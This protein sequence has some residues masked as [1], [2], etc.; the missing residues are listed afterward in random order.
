MCMFQIWINILFE[1]CIAVV[2]SIGLDE[3]EKEATE[4]ALPVGTLSTGD[5]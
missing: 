1:D 5:E 4:P 3:S 2:H